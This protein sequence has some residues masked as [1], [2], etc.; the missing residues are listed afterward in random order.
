MNIQFFGAAE[1]V[2]GSSYLVRVSNTSFLVDFGQFQGL[3]EVEAQNTQS[4][5]FDPATLDF[6]I[7]T[8]AHIDHCG[9]LPLLTNKGFTGK[10]YCTYPTSEL[11]AL[12][13]KDSGKIHEEENEWENRKRERA[14]LDPVPPLFSVEDA[15]N[16]IPYLYPIHYHQVVEAT[17]DVRFEFNATGHLLG[18]ASVKITLK[19]G[20]E[21]KCLIFSGD[22][23]TGT[24]PLLDSPEFWDAADYVVTESTYGLKVHEHV[25]E[26]AKQ[27]ASIV[28]ATITE[29]GTVLIPAFSVGRTQEVLY[30]L[31]Q[32][33]ESVQRLDD[34]S[35]LPIYIDSPLAIEATAVFKHHAR[36]LKP[37]IY[38]LY[39]AGFDPLKTENVH[40]IKD[41]E[42][43]MALNRSS[44][45]KIII[46]ASGMCEAGRI[47]HHLKHYLW[48]PKTRLVFIGYQGEGTLGRALKDGVNYVKLFN[49]TIHVA[50]VIHSLEGFSGH[51]DEPML[52]NWLSHIKGVRQVFVTH[53]EQPNMGIFADRIA[54]QCH[55]QAIVPKPLEVFEL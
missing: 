34:F 47:K 27:L 25:F 12:M 55:C 54:S 20:D 14:G 9:R 51:A 53:G 35:A 37:D 40:Y 36:Y 7:L 23:G 24:N 2:T 4:L 17:P 3:T 38:A 10:I 6:V 11:A 18:S 50:A 13:L 52:I 32:Y 33:Y 19:E 48:Q 42:T 49:D 29:G 46:S 1:Q 43:S 8:H 44:E 26:R 5:Y 41:H 31:K 21:E 39:Q 45:P 28:D 22:L 15:E 16:C 30:I